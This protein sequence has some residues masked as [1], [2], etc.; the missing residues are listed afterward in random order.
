MEGTIELGPVRGT[1]D[2]YPEDLRL[3][4]W[5]F[6]LWREVAM[7]FGY[8]EFD[9]CVLEHEELYVRKAGDEITG[10]LFN[11]TDKGGRAVALRP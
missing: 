2:F 8:E 4:A 3:R 11:F 7:S 1:R 5:L 10:Q 6:G 9:A